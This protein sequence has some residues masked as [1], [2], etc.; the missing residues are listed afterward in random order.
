[1]DRIFEIEKEIEKLESILKGIDN[2]YWDDYSKNIENNEIPSSRSMEDEYKRYLKIIQPE[3]LKIASLNR[4]KRLIMIPEFSKL[5]N[6][7]DVMPLQEFI[8]RVNSGGFIDYDG[9]GLYI[10]DNQESNI[11]IYPSDVK[12][13][14]VRKDFDTIIWFNK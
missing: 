8:E 11:E 1:M 5:P 13:N 14:S 3:S 4:E 9:Y 6:F 10:K 7:G 12:H 2:K